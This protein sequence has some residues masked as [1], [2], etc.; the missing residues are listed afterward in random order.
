MKLKHTLKSKPQST[1]MTRNHLVIDLLLCHQTHLS[2]HLIS[3]SVSAAIVTWNHRYAYTLAPMCL[4]IRTVSPQRCEIKRWSL[5]CCA[6]Y[7]RIAESP[8][9]YMYTL[10]YMISNTIQHTHVP[11][12]RVSVESNAD[13]Q[14]DDGYTC[15]Q[16]S[17]SHS[18][19]YS[20]IQCSHGGVKSNVDHHTTVT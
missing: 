8:S 4:C 5:R 7:R 6:V 12:C 13:H 20:A 2:F 18:F 14:T 9:T 19:T 16:N 3:A 10:E 11:H 17:L 15:T 1:M